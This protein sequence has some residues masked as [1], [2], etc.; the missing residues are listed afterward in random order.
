MPRDAKRHGRVAASMSKPSCAI[1]PSLLC[2][3]EAPSFCRHRGGGNPLQTRKATQLRDRLHRVGHHA[4]QRLQLYHIQILGRHL[5]TA[6]GRGRSRLE[7]QGQ[8]QGQGHGHGLWGARGVRDE[9]RRRTALRVDVCWCGE[10]VW[11]GASS[12][13]MGTLLR[14]ELLGRGTGGHA[15]GVGAKERE[16]RPRLDPESLLVTMARERGDAQLEGCGAW[17]GLGSGSG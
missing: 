14:C 6:I 2:Q 9:G 7:G 4:Q 17:S 11:S 13:V 16:R 12:V 8:G 15:R 3:Q 10:V 5:C 1:K